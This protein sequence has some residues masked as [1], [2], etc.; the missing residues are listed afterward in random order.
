MLSEEYIVK[1][2]EDPKIKLI[3]FSPED[4]LVTYPFW[5]YED[6]YYLLQKDFTAMVGKQAA[7]FKQ[8]RKLSE[9]NLIL[10][11]PYAAANIKQIYRMIAENSKINQREER[12]LLEQEIRLA[13]MYCRGRGFGINL[14]N[15]AVQTGKRVIILAD[16]VFTKNIYD[17]ILNSCRISG[18]KRIYTS[19]GIMRTKRYGSAFRRVLSDYGI[20]PE[21]MLHIGCDKV[22]D[23]AVPRYIGIKTVRVSSP[24]EIFMKTQLYSYIKQMTDIDGKN[25]D[26]D[27]TFRLRLIL[28]QAADDMF[29]NSDDENKILTAEEYGNFLA[30]SDKNDYIRNSIL[31][32]SSARVAMKVTEGLIEHIG[33]ENGYGVNYIAEYIHR[34]TND[35]QKKAL[36]KY[37]TEEDFKK[38]QEESE[39]DE[40][41]PIENK[42]KYRPNKFFPLGSRRREVI[43]FFFKI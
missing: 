11:S 15:R 40:I 43:R 3:S 6:I 1:K 2:M 8:Y 26:G 16:S 31:K 41:R 36:K 13:E 7:S 21:N 19:G 25:I 33:A 38:W 34:Y 10:K 4:L 37:M 5:K 24:K 30:F 22:C 23:R 9:Q 29:D 14:L 17:G 18:Y 28:G 27:E 12:T 39:K 42:K 20:N 32:D 35:L